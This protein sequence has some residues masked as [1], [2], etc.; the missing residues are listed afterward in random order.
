MLAASYG[1]GLFDKGLS[2]KEAAVPPVH[3]QVT[4]GAS[5]K[6]TM[7]DVGATE[8]IPC[9]MMAPIMEELEKEYAGI[10]DIIFVDV[11]KNPAEGRKYGVQTIP[12]Q[13]FFDNYGKEVFRH[14]GFLDKKP[15]VEILTRLGAV[16]PG[17]GISVDSPHKE[18]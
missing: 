10:A 9:K 1:L 17:P 3:T 7:I 6:V 18:G 4:P 5:G 15:I 13:I 14:V 16:R 12:T 8:C 2:A 11:W